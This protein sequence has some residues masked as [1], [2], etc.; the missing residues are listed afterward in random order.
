MMLSVMRVPPDV[1]YRAA[2]EL[3]L[4]DGLQ[5]VVGLELERRLLEQARETRTLAALAEAVAR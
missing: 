3:G 2:K 4:F 5:N 1:R